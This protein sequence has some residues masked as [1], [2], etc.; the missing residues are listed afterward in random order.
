SNNVIFSLHLDDKERLWIG[1]EGDGLI[2]LD[3]KTDATQVFNEKN[4]LAN[5]TVYAIK[6]EDA[7]RVWL[8]TNKGLSKIDLT[9]NRIYNYSEKDG[10][11]GGQFHEGSAL[12]S[13]EGG[14]M[15][16]GGTEGWNIFKPSEIT[17]S[18]YKPT[19]RIIGL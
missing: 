16:F 10:L 18:D 6:G 4:G 13:K 12:Y 9:E 3:T 7:D 1:T 11:Q 17:R 5:N 2:I 19:V 14:F 15:A 8:S